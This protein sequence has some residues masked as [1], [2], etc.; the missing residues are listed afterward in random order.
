MRSYDILDNNAC[1]LHIGF[2][3][4]TVGQWKCD[5]RPQL[6]LR[7]RHFPDNCDHKLQNICI[8]Q[9]LNI[10]III[11]YFNIDLLGFGRVA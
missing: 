9:I 1:G 8:L 6:V 4:V 2:M 3:T 7:A 11:K 10:F 5:H